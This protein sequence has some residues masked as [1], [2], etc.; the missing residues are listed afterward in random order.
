[1][2]KQV[3]VSLGSHIC[4]WTDHPSVVY[5]GL[6]KEFNSFVSATHLRVTVIAGI[7]LQN[8]RQI[9]S[10]STGKKYGNLLHVCSQLPS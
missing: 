1:M 4:V 3:Q 7:L 2:Q 9:R 6:I 8:V 10:K 5:I